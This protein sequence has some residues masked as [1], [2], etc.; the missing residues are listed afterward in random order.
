MQERETA[1]ESN[2]IAMID[3]AQ[4]V[5][6]ICAGNTMET[7]LDQAHIHRNGA[8]YRAGAKIGGEESATDDDTGAVHY[9]N[10]N[11]GPGYLLENPSH[12]K[13]ITKEIKKSYQLVANKNIV[14]Q[15]LVYTLTSTHAHYFC[16]D[17]NRPLIN[18][19][20][21]LVPSPGMSEAESLSIQIPIHIMPL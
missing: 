8:K 19:L 17:A 5:S 2:T 15:I 6:T 13:N 3:T 16:Q 1:N 9:A 7:D 10:P 18:P 12:K 14:P 11:P 4:Y 21:I 20:T